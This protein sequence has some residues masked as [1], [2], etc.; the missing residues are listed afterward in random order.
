MESFLMDKNAPLLPPFYSRYVHLVS[1]VS[2]PQGLL[3][4]GLVLHKYASNWTDEEAEFRYAECKWSAREVLLHLLDA[5]RV[6]AYRAL[7]FSR[8]DQT[9]LPG[10]EENDY[11]EQYV[12][13]TRKAGDIISEMRL[14]RESTAAMFAGF[15]P[16]I[17]ERQGEASGVQLTVRTLGEIIIGHEKH[18]LKVLKEKYFPN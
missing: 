3:E 8:A 2:L 4:S 6:F 9:V 18:H 7:R 1:A 11:A 13:D 12:N 5:E 10:Y 15:T 14:L 17:M 16:E